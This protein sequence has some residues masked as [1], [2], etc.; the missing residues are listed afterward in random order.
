MSDE[1][2]LRIR[3]GELRDVEGLSGERQ[4]RSVAVRCPGLCRSFDASVDLVR[5]LGR[6]PQHAARSDDLPPGERLVEHDAGR[7][8]AD[9]ER[10]AG[11]EHAGRDG[12]LALWK[13][14]PH[15]HGR[16]FGWPVAEPHED[17]SGS[18]VNR[19]ADRLVVE[20]SARGLVHRRRRQRREV[21]IFA[22][23]SIRRHLAWRR[24]CR[25]RWQARRSP[26]R[27]LPR[28]TGRRMLR[29]RG[30][31][32]RSCS[33]KIVR[34]STPPRTGKLAMAPAEPR[35][36]HGRNPSC[37]AARQV[38][39]PSPT[40]SPIVTASSASSLTAAPLACPSIRRSTFAPSGVR[41]V[42]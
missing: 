24:G 41:R 38:S 36:Q 5:T 32:R 12:D 37:R 16:R 31:S 23:S 28:A 26:P 2:R 11:G 42:R 33:A 18:D 3:P 13:E 34:H 17:G 4:G 21:K 35:A 1:L 22:V 25:T 39:M 20:A 30:G 40:V 6:E 29:P 8:V 15:Q 27:G 9:D 14:I 7:E 19:L 10:L